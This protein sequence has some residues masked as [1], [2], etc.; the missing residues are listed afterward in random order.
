[1]EEQERLRDDQ[2]DM[3]SL[4]AQIDHYKATFK[5]LTARCEEYAELYAE[6][7]K[8]HE[9]DSKACTE[10]R[11]ELKQLNRANL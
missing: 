11:A 5:K 8:N 3:R 9:E 6:Y 2:K 1:M 10:M 7:K 4:Q